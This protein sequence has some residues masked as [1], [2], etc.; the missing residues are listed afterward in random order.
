MPQFAAEVL[1]LSPV[2]AAEAQVALA[3]KGIVC[4]IDPDFRDPAGTDYRWAMVSGETKI[5]DEI[6]IG[7]WLIDLV[8][9]FAG[10]VLEWHFGP[11]WKIRD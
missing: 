8:G 11:P 7:N 5:I 6:A 9:P 3:T 10:D 2:H 4:E 1:F